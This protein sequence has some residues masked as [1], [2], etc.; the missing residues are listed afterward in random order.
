MGL[1]NE[2]VFSL[3]ETYVSPGKVKQYR[4]LGAIFVPGKREGVWEYD[5]DTGAKFMDLR[6]SGGVFNLGHNPVETK[7]AL[8][9]ALEEGLD[10]GDHI[11]ISK[12]RALLAEKLAQLLPGDIRYSVFGA[13]GGEA[14]D[15]A[16]K[17]ARGY[18][19]RVKILSAINGYHGHTGF[20]LSTGHPFF[21][22]PFQPLIPGFEKI[23]F[24]DIE[25]AEKALTEDVGAV[26]L[27]TIQAV[28][29]VIIPPPEYFP[30][31][32]EITEEK[33]IVLIIDEVQAG[34]GR[35][36]RLWA[37]NE[38]NVTP[39][40]MVL[41]K[42]MTGGLTPLSVTSYRPFLQEF[43]NQHPF[44]HISTTGG[45]DLS[46]RVASKMLDIVSDEA[47]LKNVRERG[48][49]FRKGL[50]A[51]QEDSHGLIKEIRSRGLFIGVE[52]VN[53]KVCLG[54]MR[55][56]FKQRLIANYAN[57]K[58]D[59]LIIMPPLIIN[60]E[61]VDFALQGLETAVKTIQSQL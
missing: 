12:E 31:L 52:F 48:E 35:T 16:L 58:P 26:I 47:F 25:A 45:S 1:T 7:K 34:L 39:D 21:T 11:L 42:G 53:E 60:E 56:G 27:E 41:A 24:G 19:R 5:M 30:A 9:Q 20:A 61:E 15:L 54:A 3:F 4:E 13:G 51:I 33:G 10:I 6:S 57:N 23:P 46:C 29:G 49:Q 40:I 14:I 59:T 18:T 38:W 17:L 28:G 22:E 32:R 43:F 2:D 8:I 44:I 55:E 50:E 37:I 36:G